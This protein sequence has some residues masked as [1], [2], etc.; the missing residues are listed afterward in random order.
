MKT[1]H[2]SFFEQFDGADLDRLAE[3]IRAIRKAGLHT[4]KYTQAGV[5]Q[6]SGNV[7]VWDEDWAGCVVCS[8]GF[9]VFWSYLCPESGEEHEFNTYEEIEEYRDEY[10]GRCLWADDNSSINA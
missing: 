10:E 9:D 2:T 5:N 3:C 7:W 1:S 4:S 8:V 6:G